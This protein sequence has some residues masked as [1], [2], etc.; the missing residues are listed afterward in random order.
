MMASFQIKQHFASVEHPQS[1]G[2]AKAA[3]KI[4]ADELRRRMEEVKSSWVEQL[5][6]VLWGY[7]TRIQTSIEETPFRL[8]NGCQALISVEIGQPL[9]KR[10]KALHEE[11]DNNEA[12]VVE[13]D[14]IDE[15]RVTTHCC[16]MAT[17]Q[18]IAARYNKKVKPRSFKKGDLV[19]QRVDI[20]NK[21]TREGKLATNW[22][23]SYRV[24][25]NPNKGA[26][27]LETLEKRVV[28]Q[29]WNADKLKAYYS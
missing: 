13:L 9:W 29:T 25:E 14:L 2:Q 23:G 16:D 27:M 18:L 20:G 24:R 15:V 8:T 7:R 26:Y 28:K 6:Y 22:K 5:Y 10:I 21:N 11:E 12:L 4:T 3:N 19:L 1:N 17:K